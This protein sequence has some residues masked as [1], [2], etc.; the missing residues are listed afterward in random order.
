MKKEFEMKKYVNTA[1]V[2]MILGLAFGL[3]FRE[4]T[5]YVAVAWPNQ[6]GLL[7]VHTLTLGMLFFLIVAGLVKVTK[8][9]ED[10]LFG[11]F[12]GVYNA[13]LGLTLTMLLVRGLYQA[14]QWESVGLDASIAGMAGIGHILLGTGLVLFFIALRRAE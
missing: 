3:F 10:K 6:L 14:L 1:M 8:V 7:H 11:W 4:F 9:G 2:Y 12:Y 5:K 13:G